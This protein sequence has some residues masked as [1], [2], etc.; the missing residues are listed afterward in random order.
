V[1]A[2]CF[3]SHCVYFLKINAA[4]NDGGHVHGGTF[5]IGANVLKRQRQPTKQLR[6]ILRDFG[7]KALRRDGVYRGDT[8]RR[9]GFIVFAK[10][11]AMLRSVCMLQ[12]TFGELYRGI[13]SAAGFILRTA[14]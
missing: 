13:G 5:Q 4:T 2:E 9:E 1:Q 7:T 10:R 14:K 6:K 8:K 11:F 3:K 12:C